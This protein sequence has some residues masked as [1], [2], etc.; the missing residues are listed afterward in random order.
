MN[1]QT[2]TTLRQMLQDAKFA[3]NRLHEQQFKKHFLEF[4]ELVKKRKTI[5][6]GSYFETLK[7]KWN[8]K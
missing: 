2:K 4:K 1:V 8:E 7:N 6:P 3:Q 5:T